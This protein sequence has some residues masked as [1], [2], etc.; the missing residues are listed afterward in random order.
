V[1]S[2]AADYKKRQEIDF[3]G[4]VSGITLSPDD[5]SLFVGVCDRVYASLMQYRMAHAKGTIASKI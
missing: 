5:E 1:Y 3:F 2:A 4:E